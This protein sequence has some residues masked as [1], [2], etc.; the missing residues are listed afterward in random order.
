MTE[1]R[2]ERKSEGLGEKRGIILKSF[3]LLACFCWLNNQRVNK[4][5]NQRES[6]RE[7]GGNHQSLG[8]FLSDFFEVGR[9]IIKQPRIGKEEIVRNKKLSLGS[10]LPCMIP[11]LTQGKTKPTG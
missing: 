8:Y 4:G 1:R 10:L 6:E 11:L 5:F 7:S 3:P 2:R 9:E